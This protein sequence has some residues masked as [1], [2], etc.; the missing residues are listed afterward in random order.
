LLDLTQHRD[1]AEALT[2]QVARQAKVVAPLVRAKA[3]TGAQRDPRWKLVVNA[4]VEPDL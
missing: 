4:A 3:T 2:A 1:L